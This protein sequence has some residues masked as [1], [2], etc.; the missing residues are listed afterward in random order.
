MAL[1]TSPAPSTKWA[2]PRSA[3]SGEP[4]TLTKR[5]ITP[6]GRNPTEL[7][8]VQWAARGAELGAGEILLTSMDRDGTK[9]GYDL[10]L[11]AAV[12][13]AVPVPVIASGGA[14]RLEH[15]AEAVSEGSAD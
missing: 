3:T 12:A 10:E 9:D 14:G 7:D 6:G 1:S 8:A 11:T 5:V 2:N 15:L 13:K 4:P